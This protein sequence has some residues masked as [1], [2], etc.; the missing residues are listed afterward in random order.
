MLTDNLLL[1]LPKS[2]GRLDKQNALPG[3]GAKTWFF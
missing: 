1:T 2:A 3:L